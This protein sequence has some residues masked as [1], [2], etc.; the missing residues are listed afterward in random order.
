MD[1]TFTE[2]GSAFAI[3]SP[4]SKCQ[5]QLSV[6]GSDGKPYCPRRKWQ[7]DQTANQANNNGTADPTIA[8]LALYGTEG[9]PQA[10][11]NALVNPVYWNSS[12]S[13]LVWIAALRDNSGVRD[14][15]NNVVAPSILDPSFISEHTEWI[16]CRGIPYIP[17]QHEAAARTA[18]A[19]KEGDTVMAITV[20][21][22]Q[23][24]STTDVEGVTTGEYQQVLIEGAV[25]KVNL[26]Y[27]TP[28]TSVDSDYVV[29]GT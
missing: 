24:Y 26:A 11:N 28:R 22:Q 29:Q 1:N 6:Q 15:K 20:Q 4:C 9:T 5:N 23:N 16:K 7:A 8:P 25:I 18:G 17:A 2:A 19:L 12:K 10:G 14:S 27:N 21:N 13:T 3:V